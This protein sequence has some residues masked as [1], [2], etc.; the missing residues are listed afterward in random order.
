MTKEQFNREMERIAAMDWSITTTAAT[1]VMFCAR[2]IESLEADNAELR[3][4][5]AQ[6]KA[7]Y[8]LSYDRISVELEN[9][10]L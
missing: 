5:I 4:E 2:Y 7:P 8:G 1:Q 10:S 3:A 9:D 6:L